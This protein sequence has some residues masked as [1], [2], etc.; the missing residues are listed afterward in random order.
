MKKI[1]DVTALRNEALRYAAIFGS[2]F[3]IALYLH[4][5]LLSLVSGVF[6]LVCTYYALMVRRRVN[7]EQERKEKWRTSLPVIPADSLL[8]QAF[9]PPAAPV[10]G[11]LGIFTF[12]EDEH[13]GLFLEINTT[14]VFVELREDKMLEQRKQYAL[15]LF[16]HAGTLAENFNALAQSSRE[17]L[18]DHDVNTIRIQHIGIYANIKDNIRHATVSVISDERDD[19]WLCQLDEFT[20]KDLHYNP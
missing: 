6:T 4:W 18:Q 17:M 13:Y 14:P 10:F 5:S 20:F 2:L 7:Q 3:L 1:P 11:V 16:N 19:S 9:P 15:D 12:E 8:K